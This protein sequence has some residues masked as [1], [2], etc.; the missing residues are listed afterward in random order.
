[1]PEH[2]VVVNLDNITFGPNRYAIVADSNEE[3]SFRIIYYS[4]LY[5]MFEREE[6]EKG[7]KVYEKL[8]HFVLNHEMAPTHP[9]LPLEEDQ[10]RVYIVK[11]LQLLA[12]AKSRRKVVLE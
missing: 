2:S 6:D 4:L 5:F 3:L 11:F 7:R 10:T 9:S 12:S 8:L 1:V